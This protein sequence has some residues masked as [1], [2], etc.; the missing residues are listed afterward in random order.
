MQV[1]FLQDSFVGGNTGLDPTKQLKFPTLSLES[2]TSTNSS[3]SSSS[4]KKRKRCNAYD[5]LP[6]NKKHRSLSNI[7]RLNGMDQDDDQS[8]ESNTNTVHKHQVLR[9]SSRLRNKQSKSPAHTAPKFTIESIPNIDMQSLP[10]L[11]LEAL[12]SLSLSPVHINTKTKRIENVISECLKVTWNASATPIRSSMKKHKKKKKKLTSNGKRVNWGKIECRNYE[13]RCGILSSAVPS[14]TGPSLH[15]GRLISETTTNIDEYESIKHDTSSHDWGE[16]PKKE[17]IQRV[18]QFSTED[19]EKQRLK[20]DMNEIKLLNQSRNDIGCKCISIYKMK[21]N[22]MMARIRHLDKTL[23]VKPLKKLKKE[24]LLKRLS[25]MQFEKYGRYDVCCVD[26]DCVCFREGIECQIDSECCACGG[27]VVYNN[28]LNGKQKKKKKM[29]KKDSLC[30]ANP[31][32]NTLNVSVLDYVDKGKWKELYEH[33]VAKSIESPFL[34]FK[35]PVVQKRIDEWK[36]HYNNDKD[37]CGSRSPRCVLNFQA[38]R[39]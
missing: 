30:C 9:R 34:S 21:K 38:S 11:D 14:E 1:S 28:Y 26:D 2:T 7:P 13:Q 24:D 15:L 17:R 8:T 16:L 3:T 29:N 27:D 6:P 5:I 4:S 10:K 22:D 19:V 23:E 31:N 12:S 39:D 36:E 20:E 35:S 18:K 25:A 32:G 33:D 37:K